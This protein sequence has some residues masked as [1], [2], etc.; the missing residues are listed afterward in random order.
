M[1]RFFKSAAFPILIVIVLAFFA[2][3]LIATHDGTSQSNFSVFLRQLDRF[4]L[5]LV[6]GWTVA[7]RLEQAK[8]ALQARNARGK[9]AARERCLCRRLERKEVD[10]AAQCRPAMVKKG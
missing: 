3:K 9:L 10:H 4:E 6:A 8:S 5:F 1:S 7:G 2:S